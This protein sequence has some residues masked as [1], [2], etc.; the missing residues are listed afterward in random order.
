MNDK[1]NIVN[2]TTEDMLK[3]KKSD[4]IPLFMEKDLSGFIPD[5]ILAVAAGKPESFESEEDDNGQDA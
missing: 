3:M 1:W 2:R 5:E 4:L